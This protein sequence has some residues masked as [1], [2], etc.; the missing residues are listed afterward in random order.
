M[1]DR[2]RERGIDSLG[3]LCF[4]SASPTSASGSSRFSH[5]L[6]AQVPMDFTFSIPGMAIKFRGLGHPHPRDQ[7]DSSKK[8]PA[9]KTRAIDTSQRESGRQESD[10]PAG[11][12]SFCPHPTAGI[13]LL[14]LPQP[15]GMRGF[16]P[17]RQRSPRE[18]EKQLG[19]IPGEGMD[20]EIQIPWEQRLLPPGNAPVRSHL[21]VK[22]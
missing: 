22:V 18:W 13:P 10:F 14:L 4:G 8:L 6:P 17:R 21:L 1:R 7:P 9:L 12:W 15:M 16:T 11:C 19:K 2:C 5:P 3:M 20:G